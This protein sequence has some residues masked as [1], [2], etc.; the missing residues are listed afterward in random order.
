MECSRISLYQWTKRLSFDNVGPI[1]NLGLGGGICANLLACSWLLE[2]HVSCPMRRQFPFKIWI[3]LLWKYIGAGF[4]YRKIGITWQE[5]RFFG[6]SADSNYPVMRLSNVTNI[7]IKV[8]DYVCLVQ[9]KFE[10]LFI[11]WIWF[12]W[13]VDTLLHRFWLFMTYNFLGSEL[14]CGQSYAVF[15]FQRTKQMHFLYSNQWGLKIYFRL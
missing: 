1:S 11:G 12:A 13:T 6:T 5:I 7:V 10:T 15:G 9:E 2:N 4:S 8:T 14:I 3:S